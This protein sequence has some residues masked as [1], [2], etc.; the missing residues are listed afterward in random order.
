MAS[1]KQAFIPIGGPIHEEG[2]TDMTTETAA[3][4][5]LSRRTPR[6]HA[7]DQPYP[8]PPQRDFVEPDWRRLPGYRDVTE[9]EWLN[10]KWQRQHSVKNLDQLLKVYGDLIP[11]DLVESIK[12]D[13]AER[14]T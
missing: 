9:A 13:Q 2:R 11:D 14:A 7:A 3:P 4:M 10:A 8:Y 1:R 12:R 6:A 5:P